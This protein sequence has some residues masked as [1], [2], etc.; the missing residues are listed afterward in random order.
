MVPR[1]LLSLLAAV[2]LGACEPPP[3]KEPG[4]APPDSAPPPAPAA[5]VRDRVHSPALGVDKTAI[6][7]LP[8]DYAVSTRRYPV[9]YFLHGFGGGPTDWVRIAPRVAREVGL[10]AILVMVDGDDSFY[11]NWARSADYDRCLREPRRWGPVD[12]RDYCVRQG[13]YEDYLTRDV[14]A[15]VDGRY[16]TIAS[17]AGRALVGF[18]MGGYGALVVSMRHPDLFSVAVSHAGVASLT[19]AGPRPYD[20]GRVQ[21]LRDAADWG[22]QEEREIPGIRAHVRGILGPA[23]VR[24]RAHDPVSLA[25]SLRDGQIALYLDC[26][27]DDGFGFDDLA[28]DLHDALQRRGI[29]HAF[30][31]VSHGRH[32]A[33]FLRDRLDDGLRF[34]RDALTP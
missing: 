11:V 15:H 6:V 23:L 12:P 22:S 10:A 33:A 17:R 24:W 7:V 8:D 20:A 29:R 27:T 1:T 32:D 14:L 21:R 13:R 5:I 19:Y 4:R 30:T 2:A 16:R 26:G 25:S 18:S 3:S 34:V 9:V 31:I 28:R